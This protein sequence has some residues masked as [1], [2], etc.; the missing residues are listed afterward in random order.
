[1]GFKEVQTLDA[2]NTIAL[3]GRNKKTGKAN[4]TSAEGY[5]LGTRQ[6]ESKKS[7][8]GLAAIHFLQT[9]KGNVGIWGKTDMDRKFSSVTPGTMIRVSFDKM[10]PT[11]N[12]EMYKYKVEIDENN[13]VE[14]N[15]APVSTSKL[16]DKDE[17]GYSTASDDDDEDEDDNTDSNSDYEAEEVAQASAL[18]ALE[19]KAKVEALLKGKGRTAR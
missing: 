16:A 13:T 4:P 18:S 1:M 12:G 9:S 15:A 19:R 8:N 5:Y 7:K 10:V 6:V 11:P 2:D 3:G 17:E 14:V